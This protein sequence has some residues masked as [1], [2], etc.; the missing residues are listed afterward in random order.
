M[1]YN[2]IIFTENYSQSRDNYEY[3]S[4]GDNDKITI[5]GGD[6]LSTGV[7]FSAHINT[8]EG[9]DWIIFENYSTIDGAINTG[10]G[11]DI[12][13]F[14]GYMQW[15][16]FH[17]LYP[18]RSIQTGQGNDNITIRDGAS[19]IQYVNGGSDDDTIVVKN[20]GGFLLHDTMTTQT[21]FD[22]GDGDDTLEINNTD[23]GTIINTDQG[24][25]YVKLGTISALNAD[26]TLNEEY[27]KQIASQDDISNLVG[28][29]NILN[30]VY[31]E[32][33]N[34]TIIAGDSKDEIFINLANHDQPRQ[35]TVENLGKE[36]YLIVKVGGGYEITPTSDSSYILKD[37]ADGSQIN[38]T[39]A[40]S[41]NLYIDSA[42]SHQFGPILLSIKLTDTPFEFIQNTITTGDENDIVRGLDYAHDLIQ[43]NGGDDTINGKAGNDKIYSGTG[44][45]RI[46]DLLGNNLVVAGD[47]NDIVHLGDGDDAILAGDGNDTIA[48]GGGDDYILVYNGNNLIVS[49]AG[50]DRILTDSGSDRIFAG[51]GDDYINLGR[52][53]QE[54]GTPIV[55]NFVDAG[56]GN[57]DIFGGLGQNDTIVFRFNDQSE[58]T[59]NVH[60]LE[61]GD[62]LIIKPAE[63]WQ[64]TLEP[65]AD[66]HGGFTFTD[67]ASGSTVNMYAENAYDIE[68][69]TTKLPNGAIRVDIVQAKNLDNL[70]SGTELDD[71]IFA[72]LGND[73]IN[74]KEGN[75][76]VEAGA[77]NDKIYDYLG[78]NVI[79]T[80]DGNDFFALGSGNDI[81][82]IGES[83]KGHTGTGDDLVSTGSGHSTVYTGA[84]NDNIFIGEGGATIW[85]GKG[86][87]YVQA[88][89]GNDT[90]I[91]D[92][93]SSINT[94]VE[95]NE[96]FRVSAGD[97]VLI[98]IDPDNFEM[99]DVNNLI[100]LENDIGSTV[101]ISTSSYFGNDIQFSLDESNNVFSIEF[102]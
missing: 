48:S 56:S 101:S 84:G 25:D 16:S 82:A 35:T 95:E 40:Y 92:L 64:Y 3:L 46:F 72:G 77:G 65:I 55:N 13:D 63:N 26:N 75:D 22:M 53:I 11:N 51:S 93:N 20:I 61:I 91:F 33:G 14:G 47:G 1:T 76:Y 70:I 29:E 39:T 17:D 44:N 5:K 67:S 85:A 23:F 19:N 62:K 69:A 24:N 9:D 2:E 87:D 83:A 42:V 37:L 97:K 15:S 66:D 38:I 36:D 50:D 30:S 8:S 78:D 52:S 98:K 89:N 10:Y 68:L 71:S 81:V 28:T 99:T 34:D 6:D 32:Y 7:K 31:S 79:F 73:T 96:V 80:G 41:N 86:N 12:V 102:N 43:T 59:N 21:Y 4:G 60:N 57:D 74:G 100:T 27:L 94:T 58:E 45:D 90:L 49:G 88:G 18:A 54:S